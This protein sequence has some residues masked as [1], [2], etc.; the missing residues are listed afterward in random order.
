MLLGF[1]PSRHSSALSIEFEGAWTAHTLQSKRLH[2]IP[3]VGSLCWVRGIVRFC[4]GFASILSISNQS[5]ENDALHF[6]FGGNVRVG[7]ELFNSGPFS[8]RADVF[9]RTGFI[10][11]KFGKTAAALDEPSPLTGGLAIMGLWAFD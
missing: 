4:G 1:V 7:T 8:I 6:M 2:S 9:L 10:E 5:S 3:L 11:R